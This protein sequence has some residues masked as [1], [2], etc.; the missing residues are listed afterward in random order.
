MCWLWEGLRGDLFWGLFCIAWVSILGFTLAVLVGTI[1][2]FIYSR[3]LCSTSIQSLFY[4]L[5]PYKYLITMLKKHEPYLLVKNLSATW[6]P[7]YIHCDLCGY[8]ENGNHWDLF[9]NYSCIQQ[10]FILK[11]SICKTWLGTIGNTHENNTCFKASRKSRSGIL[12]VRPCTGLVQLL[13]KCFSLHLGLQCTWNNP[14]SF[15]FLNQLEK[16]KVNRASPFFDIWDIL[17]MVFHCP[18]VE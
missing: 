3:W 11:L 13:G 8:K 15:S 1:V 4:S 14:N 9:I 18:L 2:A 5:W 10:N 16:K 7:V 12:P 17:G 6:Y